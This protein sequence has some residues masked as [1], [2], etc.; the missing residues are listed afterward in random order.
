MLELHL[1]YILL[2]L[3]HM[4]MAPLICVGIFVACFFVIFINNLVLKSVIKRG[5]KQVP[6]MGWTPACTIPNTIFQTGFFPT[7]RVFVEIAAR[8]C[9]YELNMRQL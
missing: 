1:H 3:C 9:L 5:F 4:E 7:T 6:H 2:I 8:N